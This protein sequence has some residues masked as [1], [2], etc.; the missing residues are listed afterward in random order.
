MKEG[1]CGD[2]FVAAYR[3]FLESKAEER[4]SDC[5]DQ[6]Q[7]MQACFV[8]NADCAPPRP[9]SLASDTTPPAAARAARA[10]HCNGCSLPAEVGASMVFL[11]V[12]SLAPAAGSQTTSRR[13]RSARPRRRRRWPTETKR[14]TPTPGPAAAL[15]ANRPARGNDNLSSTYFDLIMRQHTAFG[16]RSVL[17]VRW[18]L[19]EDLG[20]H[21]VYL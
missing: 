16:G 3:C 1:P 19:R 6:F 7:A 14:A 5:L 4:G 13:R 10:R 9:R 20:Q 17:V 15:M 2:V 18:H 21:H 11:H 12:V 8:E